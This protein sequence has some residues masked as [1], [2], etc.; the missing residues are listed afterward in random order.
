MSIKIVICCTIFLRF[1]IY[2]TLLVLDVNRFAFHWIPKI[3]FSQYG[4]SIFRMREYI[5]I[6]KF[7]SHLPSS[8]WRAPQKWVKMQ[9]PFTHSWHFCLMVI[10]NW[11]NNVIINF[12]KTPQL[13][14]SFVCT[15]RRPNFSP[16][17]TAS[18][19]EITAR[20]LKFEHDEIVIS[21]MRFN[22]H[23]FLLIPLDARRLAG[24][25]RLSH[26]MN[27]MDFVNVVE[28]AERCNWLYL[29]EIFA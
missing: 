14:K 17:D 29:L 16:I 5:L 19:M 6:H 20:S 27:E 10:I 21:L 26:W 1:A 13:P 24:C 2:E 12:A 15:R 11:V 3:P 22:K 18:N 23:F 28:R 8:D 4:W 9:S 7:F 25:S